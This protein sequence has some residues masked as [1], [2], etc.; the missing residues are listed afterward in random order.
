MEIQELYM[1]RALELAALGRGM[2]SPNPMV[3]CVIVKDGKIIAEGWHQCYGGAHA[4]V[5][6]INSVGDK[7]LLTNSEM[8]VTL[9][10]C[11]HFGKTP[12]CADLIIQYAFKKIYIAVADPNPLV[13][14][15]GIQKIQQH[16]ME[17]HVGMLKQEATNINNRFFTAIKKKRPYIILKWA[18]TAD[19]FI[20]RSDYSSQWISNALSRKMVHQWRAEEDALIVGT[21][22][23]LYDNPALTLRDW[24]GTPPLRIAIDLQLQMPTTAKLM[25]QSA[26]TLIYNKIKSEVSENLTLVKLPAEADVLQSIM[27]DMY[28]RRIQSLIVEGGSKLLNSFIAQNQ[29]DEARIFINPQIFGNG[30]KAPEINGIEVQNCMIKEDRLKILHRSFAT[31]LA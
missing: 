22:T 19:G 7:N 23:V 1:R 18:Q 30:I 20:A 6:A 28:E 4:E 16:G 21:H 17:V 2:V 24:S 10:P 26:P 27:S 11:S 29:W 15:K 13:G 25:D 5:N 31:H 9:E 12:P 14:G 8:Y 3:G